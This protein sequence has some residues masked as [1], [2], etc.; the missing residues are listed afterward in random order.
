MALGPRKHGADAVD[1]VGRIGHQRDVAGIQ[2]AE[3][4]VADAFLGTD[5]RQHLGVRVQLDAEA[6]VVP[7]G[8][9]PPHFRKAVGLR[10]AVVGRVLRRRQQPVNDRLRRGD[11]G[12]A[13][14]EGHHVGPGGP[15]GRNDAG[16]LH[17]GIWCQ[18]AQSVRKFHPCGLCSKFLDE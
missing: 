16:D 18:L 3:R 6:V 7:L 14:A 13:D 4:R 2:E 15:L 1:G 9:G 5:Q 10:V 12:V 17:E 11:V 8:D